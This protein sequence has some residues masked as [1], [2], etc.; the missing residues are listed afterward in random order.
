[1]RLLPGQE[2]FME[3]M[4]RR[5][6]LYMQ[7]VLHVLLTGGKMHTIDDILALPEG[8]RAELIDGEM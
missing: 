5:E 8:E 3:Q 2:D 7:H 6:A 1:M 4:V